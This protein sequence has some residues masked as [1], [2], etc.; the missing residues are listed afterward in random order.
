VSETVAITTAYFII[1]QYKNEDRSE[2]EVLERLTVAEDDEYDD[3][4]YSLENELQDHNFE[5]RFA[6]VKVEA[7]LIKTYGWEYGYEYD[8]E[9][10]IEEV[11]FDINKL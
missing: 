11:K 10:H 8:E 9:L 1:H 4:F 2:G 5:D 7:E 3:A 6:V